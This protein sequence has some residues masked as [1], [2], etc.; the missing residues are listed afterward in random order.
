M[1]F[2]GYMN[3]WKPVKI[4]KLNG[5]IGHKILMGS[6]MDGM[7]SYFPIYWQLYLMMDE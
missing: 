4:S 6:I 2:F 5:R 7:A 1:E 3:I